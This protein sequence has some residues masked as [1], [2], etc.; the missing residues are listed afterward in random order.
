MLRMVDDLLLKKNSYSLPAKS[1]VCARH[2]QP[3]RTI[4]A[5]FEIGHAHKIR[6]TPSEEESIAVNDVV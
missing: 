6:A 1:G 4:Y 2:A 3:T 5:R